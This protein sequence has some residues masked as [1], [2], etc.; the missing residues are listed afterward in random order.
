M[1][2]TVFWQRLP[3]IICY[4]YRFSHDGVRVEENTDDDSIGAQFA[5]FTAWRKTK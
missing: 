5:T 1:L 4:W 3:A 2:Q